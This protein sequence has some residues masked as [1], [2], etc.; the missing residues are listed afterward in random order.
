[1]NDTYTNSYSVHLPRSFSVLNT[2]SSIAYLA[3]ACHVGHIHISKDFIDYAYVAM[4]YYIMRVV[5]HH[6]TNY[7]KK[8]VLITD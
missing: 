1:M 2:L 6:H 4:H 7:R 8:Q 5:R 3:L